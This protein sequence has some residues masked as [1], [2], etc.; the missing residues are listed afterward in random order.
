MEFV[1][2]RT[3]GQDPHPDV[4]SQAY[5]RDRNVAEEE[6]G[7]PEAL[8]SIL[9][10]LMLRAVPVLLLVVATDLLTRWAFPPEKL[11]L[12][13]QREVRDFVFKVESFLEHPTP[14]VLFLGSSRIR[15]ALIPERFA[16]DLST[17]WG[18]PVR[19]YNLGLGGA[20]TEELY[21]LVTSHM[22]D[23]PPPYVVIACS[24]SE[25]ARVHQ[26]QFASRFLWRL[27]EFFNYILHTPSPRFHS[28]NVEYYL[29]SLLC[30]PWY[31]FK[32][33]DAISTLFE[34]RIEIWLNFNETDE[35]TALRIK[36]RKQALE[37]L[38][39]DDGFWPVYKKGP[40]LEM[41][42]RKDPDSIPI[43]ESELSRNPL[44]LDE[45]S[46]RLLK[47][48]VTRLR[49]MGCKVAVVEIPPSPY[50]QRR[51]PVLHGEGFRKWMTRAAQELDLLFIPLSPRET[52]LT[53]ALYRDTGH[54]IEAGAERYT[55]LLFKKLVDSGF[56]E[57][58]S[59]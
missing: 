23:P 13:M 3:D 53:N 14:D 55:S 28:K 49:G 21:A 26:F 34:D 30:R 24:G 56:F 2:Q 46:N 40:S 20:K 31:V 7:P 59:P 36:T 44:I 39:G 32:H 43:L 16:R 10:R 11:L 45:T 58:D 33:R 50:L 19:V 38:L 9:G 48:I 25:V 12:F 54:M 17:K 35:E 5:F 29:E 6:D 57:E 15:D 41:Q 8:R 18:R 4:L 27:P 51:S 37:R 22:T 42:L 1:L 47:Q 52:R